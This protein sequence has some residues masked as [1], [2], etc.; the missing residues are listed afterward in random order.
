MRC[1]NCGKNINTVKCSVINGNDPGNV[2]DD[3]IE[4]YLTQHNDD[5]YSFVAGLEFEAGYELDEDE[6]RDYIYCPECGKYPFKSK[7]IHAFEQ[8]EVV[9]FN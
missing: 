6:I 5:C 4:Y 7:E 9:C 2:K 8:L 3:E 1:C